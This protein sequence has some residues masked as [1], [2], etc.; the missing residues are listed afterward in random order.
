MS[1]DPRGW[2]KPKFAA[3]ARH[4]VDFLLCCNP[5]GKARPRME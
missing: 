1:I 3:S 4:G 2:F 5:I